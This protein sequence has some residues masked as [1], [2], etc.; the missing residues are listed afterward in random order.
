MRHWTLVFLSGWILIS[1]LS[2]AWAPCARAQSG[3]AR[4]H[5]EA[6]NDHYAQGNFQ[7]AIGAYQAALG[8]GYASGAL[9]YNLGN[10][11]FRV[12]NLG[13]AILYYEKARRLVPNHPKLLHSL[14]VARS[15]ANAPPPVVQGWKAL[16]APLSP[17]T[18]LIIGL[19]V[20]GAGMGALIYRY[21]RDGMLALRWAEGALLA[22]GLLLVGLAFLTSYAQTTDQRAVVIAQAA[23]L[24][25]TPTNQAAHD[26]TLSTG[27]VLR[28]QRRQPSWT[29]VRLSNGRTGWVRTD[30]LADV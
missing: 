16:V 14:D 10:A 18:I 22:G 13:P 15:A 3:E 24:F 21:W 8:T 4:R 20:Y 26:T 23:P 27:A 30:A 29:E 5:F 12:D 19:L 11:Y 6:G 1:G 2:A 7:E 17:I 28:V 9:Y 25:A